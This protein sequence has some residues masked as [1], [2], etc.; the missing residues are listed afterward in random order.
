MRRQ[1]LGAGAGRQLARIHR[2]GEHRVITDAPC[3]LDE[4]LVSEPLPQGVVLIVHSPLP[5]Q[6]KPTG[7][8]WL[9]SQI[10]VQAPSTHDEPA[11][12]C[13]ASEH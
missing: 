8:A 12:H 13:V 10:G 6:P 7:H 3:E 4:T 9:E 5:S 2:H 11:V 1:G